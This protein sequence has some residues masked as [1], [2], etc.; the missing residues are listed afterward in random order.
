MQF[1]F[2]EMRVCL[3]DSGVSA[4]GLQSGEPWVVSLY[5]IAHGKAFF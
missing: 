2:G 3:V 4:L 1:S 5:S